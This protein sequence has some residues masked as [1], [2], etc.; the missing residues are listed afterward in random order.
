MN[1][2]LKKL[3]LEV[4]LLFLLIF[5]VS[6]V[7]PLYGTLLLI[8]YFAYKLF[9]LRYSLFSMIG[10]TKFDNGDKDGALKMVW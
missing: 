3:L 9:A 10:K 4:G 5:L 6:K 1:S 2:A 8:A 7:K